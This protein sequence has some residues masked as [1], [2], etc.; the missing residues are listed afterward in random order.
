MFR[1]TLTFKFGKTIG[2]FYLIC[3]LS[4]I[5]TIVVE[6]IYYLLK[7]VEMPD[8]GLSFVVIILLNAFVI[9]AAN[10]FVVEIILF[11]IDCC[12]IK[13]ILSSRP[14]IELSLLRLGFDYLLFSISILVPIGYMCAILPNIIHM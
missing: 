9:L 2:L 5:F 12:R 6:K 7:Q 13:K 3:I 10:F 4:G 14:K 1:N 11:I 8:Y